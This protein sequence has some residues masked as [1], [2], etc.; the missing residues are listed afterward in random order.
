MSALVY[1]MPQTW[2][3]IVLFLACLVRAEARNPILRG[4]HLWDSTEFFVYFVNFQVL[5]CRKRFGS[6]HACLYNS[7]SFRSSKVAFDL[8]ASN[9]RACVVQVFTQGQLIFRFASR[10][11]GFHHNSVWKMA[12][13][14]ILINLNLK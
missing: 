8:G 9:V 13:L 1:L 11:F 4:N 5:V 3:Y 7:L 2:H 6:D 10:L 12:L 14:A